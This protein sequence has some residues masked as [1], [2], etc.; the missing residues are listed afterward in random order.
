MSITDL[1]QKVSQFEDELSTNFKNE[2]NCAKGC[3]KCC[4][5][6]ISVFE[7]E[8]KNIS[9]W[10]DNL[11]PEDKI[12]LKKLWGN[13]RRSAQDF[14]GNE[15]ESCAFL[16]NESCS[17]YDA[18]PLICRTQGNGILFK[19]GAEM[20]LDICPLNEGSLNL[21]ENKDYLNLDL[22]NHILSQLELLDANNQPRA[23]VSL[24]NLQ[25]K[26]LE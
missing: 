10:F 2:L 4:Y 16:V 8:A 22:I 26:L 14:F 17:I 9:H 24:A 18:R 1:Y 25:D 5:T 6:D 12:N 20:M 3:S 19:E 15:V 23:R 11:S 13:D 21:I 7:I